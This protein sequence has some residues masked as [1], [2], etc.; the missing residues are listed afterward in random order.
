MKYKPIP[1]WAELIKNELKARDMTQ[2]YLAN[3]S[4][5]K[6]GSVYQI[7]RREG[8]QIGMDKIRA[9]SKVLNRDLVIELL[10]VETQ[11]I[12]DRAREAGITGTLDEEADSP[13]PQS[14][15]EEAWTEKYDRLA[16]EKEA[17]LEENSQ[18]QVEIA[19]LKA[20]LL[21]L[22]TQKEK[23]KDELRLDHREEIHKKDLRITV[24]E[25][26]LEMLQD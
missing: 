14:Q 10:S 3:K 1:N 5:I 24:L 4:G 2:R 6:A 17:V 19:N 9:F 8:S 18:L 26:K 13:V 22:E 12:L 20:Q 23:E 11:R 16:R 7:T 21:T 25:T 15:E